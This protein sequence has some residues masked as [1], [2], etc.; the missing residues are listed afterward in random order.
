MPYFKDDFR[1]SFDNIL[2]DHG[3]WGVYL[4]KDKRF[5]CLHC[6]KEESKSGDPSCIYCFGMFYKIDLYQVPMRHVFQ[7]QQ[8][9]VEGEIIMSPGLSQMFGSKIY[10][11]R[12]VYPKDG[13]LWLDVEWDLQWEDLFKQKGHPVSLTQASEL[14]PVNSQVWGPVTFHVAGLLPLGNDVSRLSEHLVNTPLTGRLL[15]ETW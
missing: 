13:D 6:F 7:P 3:E 2:R 10:F 11:A 9:R 14:R 8:G 1:K 5:P 12:N 15:P 4:R